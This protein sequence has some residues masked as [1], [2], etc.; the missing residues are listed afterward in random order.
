[1]A[2][3]G[4]YR[5]RAM[6]AKAKKTK[7]GLRY[8]WSTGA[9]ATAATKAAY[10]ALLSG[11]FPD[12]VRITLPRGHTPS[13]ALAEHHLAADTAS[14]AIV[15]DAGDDPDVTHGAL[16]LATVRH[17]PRGDG[18]RFHAGTGVGVVT[19]EGLPVAP[20]EPAINPVPR[21]LM[22][23]VIAEVAARYGGGGDAE[24]TLSIP[25]G[26][27]LAKR[28]WNPRLGIVGGLSIL[29]T[30]G[31]VTP[32][33]CSAWI[34]SIHRGIDVAR[35]AGRKHVAGCTGSTSEQ[36]VQSLY[37]LAERDM[38]DM[39]DFAG[40][41]L[42]YL[43][44]HPL[45]RLTIGGGFGKL[46]K[47]AMGCKD[48]HSDRSRVDMEWLANEVRDLGGAEALCQQ[49]RTANTAQQVLRLCNDGAVAIAARIATLAREQVLAMLGGA[50]MGIAVDV[51]VVDRD[52][53]IAGR[54]VE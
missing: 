25:G 43:K 19:L 6:S 52:G 49:C 34:H 12:P 50:A 30:T 17:A 39:G 41:M 16:V 28:T 31:V 47:L 38:L 54:S 44:K 33:S 42:K 40:A 3:P 22:S 46:S 1:M 27:E 53:A 29:G 20:G 11:R 37:G 8:G 32:F 7:D 13:F 15:K 18:V 14:A 2:P 24:I 48:L 51:V 36:A 35:A 4:A 10:T 21:R 5:I 23:E 26:E 9:C 45:P